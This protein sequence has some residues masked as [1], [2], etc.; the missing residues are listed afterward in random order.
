MIPFAGK[1]TAMTSEPG[2]GKA[3]DWVQCRLRADRATWKEGE[4]PTLKADV[5]NLGMRDLSVAQAQDLCELRL[6]GEW[7]QWLGGSAI[8]SSSFPPGRLY[9]DI[10]VSLVSQWGRKNGSQ[11]LKLTPGKHTVVIAFVC[12]PGD[13]GWPVRVESNPVEIEVLASQAA[14]QSAGSPSTIPSGAVAAAVGGPAPKPVLGKSGRKSASIADICAAIKASKLQIEDIEVH[15]ERSEGRAETRDGKEVFVAG[16][17]DSDTGAFVEGRFGVFDSVWKCRGNRSYLER[18]LWRASESAP[19][20]AEAGRTKASWNGE[21]SRACAFYVDGTSPR[22]QIFGEPHGSLSIMQGLP[23]MYAQLALSVDG[24]VPLEE[25]LRKYPAQ[26]EKPAETPKP[27]EEGE[28]TIEVGDQEIATTWTKTVAT[29][30]TTTVTTTVWT[31][32]AVPG[33]TVKSVIERKDAKAT[34]TETKTVVDYKVVEPEPVDDIEP[35]DE[36]EPLDE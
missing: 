31:S 28:E 12:T 26:I 9:E 36:I 22:G 35:V 8:K 30:G 25:F 29:E 14:G 24:P 33:G 7:Y 4:V 23:V 19:A 11:P 10:P 21:E 27:V 6:D 18:V 20:G 16:H 15:F 13:E 2:W 32:D 1:P 34:T 5:R 17:R 3:L